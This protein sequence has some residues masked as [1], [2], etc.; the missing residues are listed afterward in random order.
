MFHPRVQNLFIVFLIVSYLN[1]LPMMLFINEA[2]KGLEIAD[3][4]QATLEHI[5]SSLTINNITTE[6]SS[7]FTSRYLEIQQIQKEY[8]LAHW[9][10]F[11]NHDSLK[12]NRTSRMQNEV[13]NFT[14]FATLFLEVVG[15]FCLRYSRKSSRR[16]NWTNLSLFGNDTKI[17]IKGPSFI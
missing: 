1:T 17:M 2:L 12:S 3:L 5:K 4:R 8:L 10:S 15:K 11:S 13:R 9:V 16:R 7:E 14:A 6:L